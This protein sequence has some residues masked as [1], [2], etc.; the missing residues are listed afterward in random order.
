MGKESQ[1]RPAGNDVSNWSSFSLLL[2]APDIT[3]T[4]L[5][6]TLIWIIFCRGNIFCFSLWCPLDRTQSVERRNRGNIRI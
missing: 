1:L 3:P 4:I 5:T 6:T 2:T